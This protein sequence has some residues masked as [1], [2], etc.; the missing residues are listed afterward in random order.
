MTS[1]NTVPRADQDQATYQNSA[2]ARRIILV[3]SSGSIIKLTRTREN[4]SG[5][6]GSGSDGDSDRVFTLTTSNSV[7]IVEVYLDGVLLVEITQY[8]INNS[9]KTVTMVSTPVF[10]SQT[11]SIFYNQ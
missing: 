10:D 1:D 4:L 11:I 2:T 8:N 7:D 9:A 5:S 6:A 3:D